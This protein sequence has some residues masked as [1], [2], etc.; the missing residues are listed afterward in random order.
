MENYITTYNGNNTY[1]YNNNYNTYNIVVGVVGVVCNY[2]GEQITTNLVYLQFRR[3][4]D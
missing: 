1:N 4:N 2:K 3:I